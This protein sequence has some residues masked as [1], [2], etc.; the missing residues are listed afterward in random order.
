MQPLFT[1]LAH[2]GIF[3]MANLEDLIKLVSLCLHLT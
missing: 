2:E 3:T 1:Q